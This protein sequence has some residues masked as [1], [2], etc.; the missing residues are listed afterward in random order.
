MAALLRKQYPPAISRPAWWPGG[1]HN[2]KDEGGR[3][4]DEFGEMNSA[5]LNAQL[6]DE[7]DAA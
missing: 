7:R 5:A 6:A 3:V 2:A 1:R 4:K